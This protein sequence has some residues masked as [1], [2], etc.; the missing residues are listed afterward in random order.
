MAD[1][2]RESYT[3][4]GIEQMKWGLARAA[5]DRDL[6]DRTLGKSSLCCYAGSADE[7][8][9]VSFDHDKTFHDRE[10]E[11]GYEPRPWMTHHH[12]PPI[13]RTRNETKYRMGWQEDYQGK[14][15]AEFD[16][17]AETK[18]GSAGFQGFY[19]KWPA[20]VDKVF[21]GW[22]D[23]D[24]I[25]YE[26]NF[27]EAATRLRDAIKPLE[28]VPDS[29]EPYYLAC[30]SL[31]LVQGSSPGRMWAPQING[32]IDRFVIPLQGT[33]LNLGVLGE[34]LAAQLEGLGNM[35]RST[36]ISV[37]EI[38]GHATLRMSG[39]GGGDGQAAI[40]AAGWVVGAMGLVA[41]PTPVSIGLGAAGLV[42]AAADA[43]VDDI[44]HKAKE[45]YDIP[46]SIEGATAEEIIRSVETT[47]DSGQILD[48][49]TQIQLDESD[50]SDTLQVALRHIENDKAVYDAAA[51]VYHTFFTMNVID[52]RTDSHPE[53]PQDA[54]ISVEFERLRAAGKTFADELGEELRAVSRGVHEVYSTDSSWLRPELAGGRAI[55]LGPT[56][57]WPQWNGVRTALAR[58]L[59][60]TSSQ[61]VELGEYLIAVANYLERADA[62]AKEALE[63]AGQEL[64]KTFK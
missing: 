8:Y 39:R 12:F 62:S 22:A 26:K 49:E 53:T 54:D 10:N 61:V 27:W 37:M 34:M 35:W 9:R 6:Q 41:L 7:G 25:P 20:R 32:P 30:R 3:R 19:G 55:G 15:I 44:K 60:V 52:V 17:W 1:E 47:L 18:S 21:T 16:V 63:K 43:L 56:G 50:S 40:K 24:H 51:N 13:P 28:T 29:G 42:L 31:G 38:G 59:D 14:R 2:R 36:R 33:L 4:A 57:P 5:I 23:P 64:D 48:L 58:I 45:V 11:P 46:A